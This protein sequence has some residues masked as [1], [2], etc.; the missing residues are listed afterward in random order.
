[1][2]DSIAQKEVS[3]PAGV[4]NPTQTLF[5]RKLLGTATSFSAVETTA[6]PPQLCI[7]WISSPPENRIFANK[8]PRNRNPFLI[9]F[10]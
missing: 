9:I 4:S 8:F 5:S 2:L 1:M 7:I 3:D 6:Y 10:S